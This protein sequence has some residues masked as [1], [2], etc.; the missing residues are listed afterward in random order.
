MFDFNSLTG[1]EVSLIEDLSG[2]AITRL[3][4]NEA[5][6]GKFLSAVYFVAKRREDPSFKFNDALDTR[7]DVQNSYL[8]FTEDEE[9]DEDVAGESNASDENEP[10]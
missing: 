8:G 1:R 10:A 7:M 9:E 3:S 5:P 2:V 6:K 4:D